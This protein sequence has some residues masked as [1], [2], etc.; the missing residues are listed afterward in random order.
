MDAQDLLAEAERTGG[1]MERGRSA[2]DAMEGETRAI[3]KE[4]AG[5]KVSW[6]AWFNHFCRSG[7]V[8]DAT[9]EKKIR[10]AAD[11]EISGK[12]HLGISRVWGIFRV[13]KRR[14][15]LETRNRIMQ[16][17]RSDVQRY[18]ENQQRQGIEREKRFRGLAARLRGSGPLKMSTKHRT[19]VLDSLKRVGNRLQKK[20]GK[21]SGP[22]KEWQDARNIE[23]MVKEQLLAFDVA[24]PAE[25]ESLLEANANGD[26]TLQRAVERSDQ[27]GEDEDARK[28]LL[29][30]LKTLRKGGARYYRL[31]ASMDKDPNAENLSGRLRYLGKE[32]DVVG[33][34]VRIALD[35]TPEDAFITYRG[36]GQMVL[37]CLD[38]ATECIVDA[39]T[40]EVTYRD[41]SG[42]MRDKKLTEQSFFLAA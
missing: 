28:S 10:E 17:I 19:R 31:A 30:Q 29:D 41:R 23:R 33:R 1:K 21:G 7:A 36:E 12:S 15:Y 38:S 27:L 13:G 16:R 39:Q 4:I 22:K 25:L 9:Y 11:R 5:T 32:P 24:D 34:K 42:N 3:A 40:A 26:K 14:L 8:R 37:R 6:L 35:G 20:I 2:M 18:L